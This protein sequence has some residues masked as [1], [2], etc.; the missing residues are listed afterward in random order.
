MLGNSKKMEYW[1]FIALV[2][3]KGLGR[4]MNLIQKRQLQEIWKGNWQ[5]RLNLIQKDWVFKKIGF[6]DLSR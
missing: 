3:A 2:K 6:Q 4:K 1:V 5:G